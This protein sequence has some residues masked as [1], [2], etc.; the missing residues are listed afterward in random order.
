MQTET[1]TLTLS[2]TEF[3]VLR[4]AVETRIDY[5]K[6]IIRREALYS[7]PDADSFWTD[8]LKD[9]E[10]ILAVLNDLHRRPVCRA[11]RVVTVGTH[12]DRAEAEA[13]ISKAQQ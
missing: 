1:I 6:D 5:M 3:D 2:K 7:K 13:W 11:G 4:L 10:N 8:R 12:R 9:A